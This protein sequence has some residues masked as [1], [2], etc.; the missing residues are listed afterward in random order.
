M[1]MRIRAKQASVFLDRHAVFL[2][3]LLG[4]LLRAWKLGSIPGG[5]NQDE[6]SGAYDAWALL[7]YGIDR[8]GFHNPAMFVAWGSGM[9]P[10]P[11]YLSTPFLLLFGL[12]PLGIRLAP[13]LISVLSLPLF[14]AFSRQVTDRRTA[15]LALFLLVIAPWH[16]MTA[17]WNHEASFLPTFFLAGV[18]CFA[19]LR[20]RHRA[21]LAGLLFG[22]AIYTYGPAYFIVPFFFGL[23]LLILLL[24]RSITLSQA[25]AAVGVFVFIALPALLF[26]IVNHW[27]L[28]SIR[29]PF[30]DIPRLPTV[31]HYE[32]VSTIFG[33]NALSLIRENIGVLWRMLLQQRDVIWNIIPGGFGFLYVFSTPLIALGGIH[34]VSSV[35]QWRKSDARTL[36]VLWL[37][38]SLALALI[39]R[40]NINRFT[41]S[42]FPLTLFIAIGIQF[43]VHRPRIKITLITLYACAG[44]VFTWTYFR[45][46]PALVG[47][48]FFESFPEAIAAASKATDGKICITAGV[49]MPYIFVLLA[50]RMDPHAFL[51]TVRYSDPAG[52]FR[53]VRS[54]DRYYLTYE[55][56]NAQVIDAFVV[57]RAAGE[58]RVWGEEFDVQH[59]KN[60]TVAVRRDTL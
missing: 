51:S 55:D 42:F 2:L 53:Y 14:Y 44:I 50:N 36:L 45:T 17:R 29:T 47:P 52:E 28:P 12:T 24:R 54:F 10:L 6:A 23:S 30:I 7:H 22:L 3:I 35:R 19:V 46:Y 27:H 8:N 32:T 21:L 25:L 58:T 41:V 34:F 38:V 13:F 57:D 59:L 20:G 15:I 26:F 48:A 18:C 37:F 33:P 31:A 9:H 43:F 60:Y 39:L 1:S 16:V 11:Y 40:A 4:I 49:N 5:I 56:C